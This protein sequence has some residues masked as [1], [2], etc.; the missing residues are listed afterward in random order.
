MLLCC[1]A[2]DAADAAVAVSGVGKDEDTN[3][4][5]WVAGAFR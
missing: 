1:D 4:Q 5:T 2:V 3:M